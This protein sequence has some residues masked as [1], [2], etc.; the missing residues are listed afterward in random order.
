MP[1]C[2]DVFYLVK[3]YKVSF[4]LKTSQVIREC[5]VGKWKHR[6]NTLCNQLITVRILRRLRIACPFHLHF[7]YQFALRSSRET[8]RYVLYSI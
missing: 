4:V 6:V 1:M 8:A 7:A 3:E 5:T 2:R